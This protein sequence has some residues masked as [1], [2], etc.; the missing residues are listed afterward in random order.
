[1]NNPTTSRAEAC[2]WTE[3]DIGSWNTSCGNTFEF[4]DGGPADNQAAFCLYCG[5]AL[6]AI[7][8]E[9]DTE[10]EEEPTTPGATHE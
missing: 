7:A 4:N 5:G 6:T 2:E 3:N 9:L 1:M 10:S 8:Y